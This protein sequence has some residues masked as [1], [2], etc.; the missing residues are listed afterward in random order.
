MVLV[1][2]KA[3]LRTYF[4]RLKNVS[5]NQ[6]RPCF[7]ASTESSKYDHNYVYVVDFGD[8]LPRAQ[9]TVD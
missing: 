9:I 6:S 1:T 7:Y 5:I 3:G 8:H 2:A 4:Y